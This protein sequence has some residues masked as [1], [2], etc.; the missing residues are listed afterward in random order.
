MLKQINKLYHNM[1]DAILGLK[2]V[3]QFKDGG[4]NEI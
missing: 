4:K 3:K 2:T 1:C